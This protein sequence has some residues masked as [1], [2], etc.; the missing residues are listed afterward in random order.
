MHGNKG[1]LTSCLNL[2]WNTQPANAQK[3]KPYLQ[4]AYTS[5]GKPQ[6]VPNGEPY[7][8]TKRKP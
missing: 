6:L 8:C 3:I 4:V 7:Q 5:G 2:W 1:S